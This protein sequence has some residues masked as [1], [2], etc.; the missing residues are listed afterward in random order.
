MWLIYGGIVEMEKSELM[1]AAMGY[2][3][4]ASKHQM[5]GYTMFEDILYDLAEEVGYDGYSGFNCY[6]DD[7]T[8]DI[9]DRYPADENGKVFDSIN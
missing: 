7:D 4:F 8:P 3:W 5:K 2:I 9:D 6:Y 1:V